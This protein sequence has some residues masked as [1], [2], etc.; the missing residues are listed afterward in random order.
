MLF[1]PLFLFDINRQNTEIVAANSMLPSLKEFFQILLT[2]TM[3]CFAWIFFRS[4]DLT[5][6]FSFIYRIFQFQGNIVPGFGVGLF[7]VITAIV[8]DWTMR[9]DERNIQLKNKTLNYLLF[10]ILAL[11]IF[12]YWPLSDAQRDFIYFQ[13]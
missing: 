1:I 11:C 12:Y 13:F 2:F 5:S 9:R 4:A 6:S 3:V 8:L 10:L 7:Y